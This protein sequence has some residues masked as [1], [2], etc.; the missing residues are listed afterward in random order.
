MRL[1]NPPVIGRIEDDVWMMDM[2]TVQD[3][4][5]VLIGDAV[6]QALRR[7]GP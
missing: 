5:L 6:A 4:E 2:R 1:G 7:N 3:E